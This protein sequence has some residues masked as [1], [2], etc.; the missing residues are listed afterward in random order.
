MLYLNGLLDSISR[1]LMH[2]L[3]LLPIPD[4]TN[5]P[6]ALKTPLR[7]TV[8]SSFSVQVYTPLL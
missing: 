4:K 7:F 5:Q 3:S 6:L 2:W 8:F 1:E